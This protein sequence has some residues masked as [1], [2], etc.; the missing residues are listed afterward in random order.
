M[1]REERKKKNARKKDKC[2]ICLLPS[3]L[4]GMNPYRFITDTYAQ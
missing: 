4:D 1:R 3:L 2:I